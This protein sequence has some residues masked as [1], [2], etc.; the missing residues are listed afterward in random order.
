MKYT[1]IGGD[2]PVR[3]MPDAR[4]SILY[5]AKKQ[6][7]KTCFFLE[8]HE[9]DDG[10]YVITGVWVPK[11]KTNYNTCEIRQKDLKLLGEKYIGICLKSTTSVM[12]A[13]DFAFAANTMYGINKYPFLQVDSKGSISA[14]VVNGNIR[15]EEI[16]I[17]IL[18]ETYID[19]VALSKSIK[20]VQYEA[21]TY[22]TKIKENVRPTESPLIKGD[23]NWQEIV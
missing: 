9:D 4:E 23:W 14:A 13:G 20:N 15:I 21:S 16:P 1:Y 18:Y 8:G 2:I 7:G 12:A 6:T 22:N 17:D 19:E 3:M 10:S 11:Q 5:L